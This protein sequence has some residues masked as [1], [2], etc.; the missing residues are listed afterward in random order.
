MPKPHTRA[1]GQ[2]RPH[3]W[4]TGPDPVLHKKYLVWLQQKNQAQFRSE[5]WHIDF[6]TWCAIWG[7]LWVNRG[8]ERGSL[9]MTRRDWA[10]PWTPDNVIIVTREQHAKTQGTARAQGWRSLRQQ[11]LRARQEV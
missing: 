6:D 10:A 5:G 9:C 1:W 11:A 8:R 7:E 3:L 2:L 4:I